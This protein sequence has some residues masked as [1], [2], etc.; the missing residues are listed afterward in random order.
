MNPSLV[1]L[2]IPLG[3]DLHQRVEALFDTGEIAGWCLLSAADDGP[4]F[5]EGIFASEREARGAWLA[6]AALADLPA[7][8]APTPESLP[9]QDWQLSYREH[10][11]AWSFGRLH[12]VPEW[13]RD[14]YRL[15]SGHRALWL[16]PGLAFGTGNHETTRL[17]A[18]RL[19]QAASSDAGRP[20]PRSLLDAG[21]GS[22]ILALSAAL[23][24]IPRIEAF[25]NDPEAVRISREN[26]ARNG[27]AD[28]VV[29]ALAG[30]PEGLDGGPYDLVLAN[31]QADVLTRFADE[32]LAAVAPGGLL[33]LSG[34]LAAECDR[35]QAAFAAAGPVWSWES[36]RL[37]EWADLA[38]RRPR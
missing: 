22:G 9:P 7:E 24:G 1:R 32:L 14:A 5:L 4:V 12:W 8:P 20:A 26:A 35:I 16:D 2:R 18:E 13:E 34:I 21:C 17:C 15:P 11:K 38:G 30:L 10:F 29:F 28:A 23:L 31:I 25:D 37:G 27:L 33:V 19:V 6:L 36:R 3:P